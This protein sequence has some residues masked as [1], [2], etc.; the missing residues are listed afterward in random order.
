MSKNCSIRRCLVEFLSMDFLIYSRIFTKELLMKQE[1]A[2]KFG[3]V[4]G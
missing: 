4:D 2:R 1:M 3:K